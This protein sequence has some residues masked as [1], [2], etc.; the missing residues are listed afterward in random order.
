MQVPDADASFTDAQGEVCVVMTA[1]CLPVLFCNEEGTQVAAAHAGWRGLVN[2]VLEQT[3]SHFDDSSKVMVWLGPAIGSSAF[4]VGDEVRE[5]FIAHDE[6]AGIAF[7]AHNDRCLQIS[8]SSPDAAWLLPVLLRYMAAI[9]APSQA[10]P[11]FFL[12]AE[13]V[14]QVVRQPVSGSVQKTADL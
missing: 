4:E 10:H 11:A 1:D 2:G 8:I 13:K 3:L 7:T 14:L 6:G 5:Q 9:F 12:I